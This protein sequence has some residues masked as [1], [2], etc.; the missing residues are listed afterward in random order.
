MPGI[1][2]LALAGGIGK[3]G[4]ELLQRIRQK[5]ARYRPPPITRP[6][7]PPR[8]NKDFIKQSKSIGLPLGLRSPR[9][10]RSPATTPRGQ[11]QYQTPPGSPRQKISF[12]TPVLRRRIKQIDDEKWVPKPRRIPL[13]PRIYPQKTYRPVIRDFSVVPR[14]T[15]TPDLTRDLATERWHLDRAIRFGLVGGQV[16]LAWRGRKRR[17]NSGSVLNNQRR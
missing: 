11:I 16:D 12:P 13:V 1:E 5:G 15:K 17:R 14:F 2:K 6:R 4:T 8:L 9:E 3:E 7:S 10:G